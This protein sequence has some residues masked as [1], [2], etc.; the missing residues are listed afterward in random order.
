MIKFNSFKTEK[1]FD[2]F[3]Q[4]VYNVR[5]MNAKKFN[6]L[7][8]KYGDKIIILSTCLQGNNT[9]RFLVLGKLIT[10]N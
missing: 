9:R 2:R 6:D 1:D 5:D 7:R 4:T 3:I 10:D 8:P